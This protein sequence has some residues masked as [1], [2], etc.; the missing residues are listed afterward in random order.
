MRSRAR[1]SIVGWLVLSGCVLVLGSRG[2]SQTKDD[3]TVY[4]PVGSLA[5]MHLVLQSQLKAVKDWVAEKDFVSA[6]QTGRGLNTLAQ[7]YGYQFADEGWR[8]HCNSL[9][10]ASNKLVEAAS[11]KSVPECQQ[12]ADDCTRL[13]DGLAEKQPKA[14]GKV[15]HKGF[16]LPGNLRVWMTLLDGSYVDAKSSATA[17][18]LALRTEVIATQANAL[19]FLRSSEKWRKHSL[20]VRDAALQVSEQARKNDFAEA[21]KALKTIYQRCE[22]CHEDSK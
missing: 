10:A 16:K 11:K 1:T 18:E 8:T 9:A 21:R 12:A 7:L 14:A 5:S 17:K 4:T 22:A 19:T 15:E 13:I 6:A 2:Q 20:A 3:P